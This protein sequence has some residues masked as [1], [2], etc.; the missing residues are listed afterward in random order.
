MSK[1]LQ[2]EVKRN[3][4]LYDEVKHRL[5]NSLEVELNLHPSQQLTK[6]EIKWKQRKKG[7]HFSQFFHELTLSVAECL[8]YSIS[9]Q[10]NLKYITYKTDCRKIAVID[11]NKPD[12][13]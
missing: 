5:K 11:S 2:N 10:Q 3:I 8:I 4:F 12:R 6:I 13:D 1:K 7:S 9:V